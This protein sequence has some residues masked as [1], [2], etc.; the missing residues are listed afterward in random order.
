MSMYLDYWG[1]QHYP[2]DDV[3]EAEFFFQSDMIEMLSDDLR[4]AILRRRGA[5]AMTGEIG[6]GKTTIS[7]RVLLNLPPER[8]DI[9][10][11]TNARLQPEQMMLEIARQLNLPLES[12]DRNSVMEQ[13]QHHLTRNADQGRDSVICIDE[14]QCVPSLDTFEE[15]RLLLNFQLGNRFLITLLLVGQPELQR[16]ISELPQLQQRMAL[17][18][19]IGQ[20]QPK[21]LTRYMLHRL[22]VAGCRRP[23]LTRQAAE[24][25]FRHTS[26][27]PRRVNHLMDR[28]LTIG[29]RQKARIIDNRLVAV[30][31]QLYPC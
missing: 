25:I 21:D 29:M 26:G 30:T 11:I 4:Q 16:M 5:V 1:L 31:T 28:C 23:V 27:V 18:L 12:A 8:F 7:Q 2:F 14:A 13:I 10:W 6:C 17:N 15:L 3:A 19:T 9:A 24:S 22:R 20:Y